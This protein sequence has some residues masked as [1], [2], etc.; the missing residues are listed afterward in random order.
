METKRLT[1]LLGHLDGAVEVLDGRGKTRLIVLLGERLSDEHDRVQLPHGVVDLVRVLEAAFAEVDGRVVVAELDVTPADLVIQPRLLHVVLGHGQLLLPHL[2]RVLVL[3][4]ARIH[5]AYVLVGARHAVLVLARLGQLEI[6]LV[7][8]KRQRVLAHLEV[9]IADVAVYIAYDGLLVVHH[10][11]V[12][13]VHVVQQLVGLVQRL[14][15]FAIR[16]H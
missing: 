6:A 12:L 10:V 1:L 13:L 4:V 7:R 9:S 11:L 5:A 14:G 15:M 2:Q 8:L 16:L 3:A